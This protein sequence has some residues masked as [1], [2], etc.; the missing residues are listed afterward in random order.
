[1]DSPNTESDEQ[2]RIRAVYR[3]W[4]GGKELAPYAWH[5]PE[6]MEQDAARCRAAG[7]LLAATVGHD[8]SRLRI[9][10]VGCGSG[11]FLRQL[12]SWG[13]RPGNL[14]GT[15]Y[16]EDR[17]D[18]ARAATARGVHWHLG[19]LDIFDDGSLDLAVA[20]TVFSSILDEQMRHQLADEMWRVLKPGA[21]CM[22]FDFRY[23]NPANPN[24]RRVS[25][26]QVR[27][28]WPAAAGHH[29]QTL[30]L[31]PPIARR[32]SRAPRLLSDLLAT[33]VPPL[34]SHF[35]YMAQKP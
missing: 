12:I 27:Q 11:G 23:N 35:I 2:A 7:G 10:D 25:R 29:Y 34:R 32:L 31:A 3:E 14:I 24:V 13:A 21:W 17:L 30:L 4:H 9:V 5:R 20:N 1:M 15:E 33:F 28:Y 16:Q 8:L 22:V 26:P 19:D 6:V 18:Q